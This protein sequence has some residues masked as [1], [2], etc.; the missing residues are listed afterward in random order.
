MHPAPDLKDPCED[1][2]HGSSGYQMSLVAVEVMNGLPGV[3]KP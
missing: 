1:G 3:Q 2:N